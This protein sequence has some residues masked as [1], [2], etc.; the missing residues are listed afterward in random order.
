MLN[1][2]APYV[3]ADGVGSADPYSKAVTLLAKH[4]RATVVPFDP[5]A[6][7]PL[8]DSLRA[9]SPEYVA[10]VVRPEMIDFNLA[11]R[12]LQMSTEIDDDPFVDFS[13]GFITGATPADAVALLR[14]SFE[15]E[16]ER[17]NLPVSFGGLMVCLCDQ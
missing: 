11:R 14:R 17:D 9:L 7:D 10:V 13:Y 3:V 12:F 8:R 5:E 1:P 16:Q 6:L 2:R 4:R 15:L